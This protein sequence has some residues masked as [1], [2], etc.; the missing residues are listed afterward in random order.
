MSRMQ[1]VDILCPE[2][3]S[4]RS[5]LVLTVPPNV[6]GIAPNHVVT[7]GAL[8]GEGQ[9][10]PILPVDMAVLEPRFHAMLET[11]RPT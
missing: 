1:G 10:P 3:R 2:G 8:P 4:D 7:R 11:L 9:G 6:S 5:M